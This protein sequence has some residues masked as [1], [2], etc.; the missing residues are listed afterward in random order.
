M[1]ESYYILHKNGA[2]SHY[3][4]LDYL[5]KENNINLVYREFSIVGNFFKSIKRLDFKLFIKQLK[6]LFFLFQLIISSN[7]KVVLGIAPYDAKL[8]RLLWVLSNH[9][10]FYH[11]SWTCWDKTFQPKKL[12]KNADS[13]LKIWENFLEDK[14][15]HI[16]AVTKHT[17]NEILNNYNVNSNKVSVVY[18]SISN[19]F[20]KTTITKRYNKKS[21]IYVGRLTPEKGIEEMLNFFSKNTDLPL[22]IIGNGKLKNEVIENSKQHKNIKY[23]EYVSNR[24]LLAS[25]FQENTFLI[26]NSKKTRKWE[27][28]FGM[29]LIEAMSQGTIPISTNHSGPNEIIHKDLGFLYKEGELEEKIKEIIK[30]THPLAAMS[31]NCI[32]F[33]KQFT[34]LENAK[35]WKKI[36]N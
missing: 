36:L 13:V 5:L 28:L 8:K 9:Q 18:H 31:E 15:Q 4:A 26:L 7:K 21:F 30:N 14:C 16:F 17:K 33:S 1:K 27:E 23:I 35:R 20:L 11:T 32:D 6:N 22:T 12:K 24:A 2:N 19:E 34:I 3:S 10:V 29:V 25:Y